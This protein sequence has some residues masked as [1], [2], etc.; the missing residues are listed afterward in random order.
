MKPMPS[1]NVSISISGRNDLWINKVSHIILRWLFFSSQNRSSDVHFMKWVLEIIWC[2]V[3]V[4]K[5]TAAFL[6]GSLLLQTAYTVATLAGSGMWA[7]FSWSNQVIPS[8]SP[9]GDNTDKGKC[10]NATS[11][12]ENGGSAMNHSF[13]NSHNNYVYNHYYGSVSSLFDLW[14][15]KT[16]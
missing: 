8:S 9:F 7:V 16:W 15:S 5:K 4:S 12:I 3:V 14:T 11:N 10:G 6:S 2:S 1:R 13:Y